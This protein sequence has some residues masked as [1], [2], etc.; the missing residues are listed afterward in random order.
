[1]HPDERVRIVLGTAEDENAVHRHVRHHLREPPRRALRAKGTGERVHRLALGMP[2]D[3]M[4]PRRSAFG[5][6]ARIRGEGQ[7]N[8]P[9]HV[10]REPVGGV[11]PV[12]VE[13][14]AAPVDP[15]ELSLLG[16]AGAYGRV[17]IGE[18]R[19]GGSEGRASPPAAFPR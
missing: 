9:E 13:P 18:H 12:E 11:R 14:P 1:M 6:H 19:S 3:R 2:H 8:R 10:E 15:D 16:E 5:I 7:G 4:P 17:D